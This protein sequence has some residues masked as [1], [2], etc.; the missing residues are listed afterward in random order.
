M[1]KRFSK[2][3]PRSW[4][5]ILLLVGFCLFL[6]FSNLNRWD[7]WNP[8]EPLYR[9]AREMVNGGLDPHAL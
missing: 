2:I 1:E 5:Q 3:Y 4:A 8:D 7:L 9:V 6:F